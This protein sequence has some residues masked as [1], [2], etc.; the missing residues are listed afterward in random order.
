MKNPRGPSIPLR[1]RPLSPFLPSPYKNPNKPCYLID[2]R[3]LLA[4]GF[5]ALRN[6]ERVWGDPGERF[7]FG[8][9][10]NLYQI[11]ISVKKGVE[12]DLI[13]RGIRVFR[14]PSIVV[15]FDYILPQSFDSRQKLTRS[16]CSIKLN[17]VV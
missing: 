1:T 4:D 10:F 16:D 2:R 14:Y 3:Y 6:L 11:K 13:Y 9:P 5:R 12:H 8:T 15:A 7:D 17:H